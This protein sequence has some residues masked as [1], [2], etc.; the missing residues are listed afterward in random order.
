MTISLAMIYQQVSLIIILL[1]AVS[2]SYKYPNSIEDNNE[3]N[4]DEEPTFGKDDKGNVVIEIPRRYWQ[5]KNYRSLKIHLSKEVL[6]NL[7]QDLHFCEWC[8]SAFS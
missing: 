7:T 2:F 6:R 5:G 4:E 1:T 8:I 3:T